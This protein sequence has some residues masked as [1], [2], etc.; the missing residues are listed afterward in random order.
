MI[1]RIQTLFLAVIAVA[2]GVVLSTTIWQKL[3]VNNEV[4][5]LTALRLTHTKMVGA[6]ASSVVTPAY[7]VAILAALI[8]GVSIYTIFQYRNRVLQMGMCA[9]N[10][11]LLT[12]LMGSVLYLT[13]YKGKDFFNPSDQGQFT[14]GFYAIVVALLCNMF[15]N[16]FIRRDEKLV[17]ESNRLR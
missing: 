16:R 17:Q 1:Q 4:A 3:G 13:L 9:V 6:T 10:A 5:E 14:T 7:Y 11:L 8:I 15:A 12:G 2:M